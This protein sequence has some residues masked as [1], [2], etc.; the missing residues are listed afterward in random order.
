VTYDALSSW[1]PKLEVAKSPYKVRERMGPGFSNE[2]L[3]EDEPLNNKK[4][5]CVV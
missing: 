3:L 1:K 5:P 2:K 4:D